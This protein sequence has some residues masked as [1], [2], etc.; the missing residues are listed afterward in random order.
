MLNNRGRDGDKE[1]RTTGLERSR[2]CFRDRA[3]R[4][5]GRTTP[6]TDPDE[7]NER[8]RFLRGVV[9]LQFRVNDSWCQQGKGPQ[10]GIELLPVGTV[11]SI[12]S[13]QPLPPQLRH[14]PPQP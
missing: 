12:P 5:E 9:S 11:A 6:P 7:R 13:H 1:L 14:L 10:H 8:I 3:A 4:P 2:H